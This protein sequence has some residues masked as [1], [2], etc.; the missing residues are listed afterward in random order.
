MQNEKMECAADR[1]R[2]IEILLEKEVDSELFSGKK[3]GKAVFEHLSGDGSSRKFIRVST[4]MGPICIAVLPPSSGKRDMAEFRAAL[5]IGRHLDSVGTPVPKILAADERIGLI[6]FEDF[7]DVRL[8]DTLNSDRQQGLELYRRVVKEL[9]HLQV[10]GASGLDQDWCYD[11]TFYDTDVM[12]KRESGYFLKAFWQDTIHAKAVEG[13]AEEFEDIAA[14]VMNYSEPF[15]LHRDFQSRNIMICNGRI[16][17]ID[18]QA[19]RFGPPGYDLASLL[20]DPYAALSDRQQ[21]ELFSLYIDEI[22]LFPEVSLDYIL[23]SYPFL[24]LQRN[25]QI[26]GAFAYLSEKMGK[27]FFRPYILPSLVMLEKR[28]KDKVF[29]PYGILQRTVADAITMYCRYVR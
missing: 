16:G 11:T 20:I 12:L 2:T 5:E 1:E 22:R 25:L 23:R 7:G 8:H 27:S 3:Q 29:H 13:L 4:R 28:L 14:Q 26:I 17:I 19:A 15:F 9:A 21:D 10:K 6:L 18:F 24:A